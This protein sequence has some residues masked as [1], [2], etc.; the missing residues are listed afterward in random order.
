MIA[1][2][3]KLLPCATLMLATAT[4]F[5]PSE[6][7]ACS[8]VT[9]VRNGVRVVNIVCAPGDAAVAPFQTTNP[10]DGS[11]IDTLTMTGGSIVATGAATPRVDGVTNLDPSAGVIDLLGG[12]DIVTISGGTIGTAA[13]PIGIVLGAGADTFNMSGG[14]ISGS[15]FGLGGG[16]I[17]RVSGG[18]IVGSLFA[19]SQNDLVTI[20]GS[21]N[22]LGDTTIGPDFVGLEDGNDRFIMT[23]GTL[24]GAVSGGN[25]NDL[26]TISGGT[27]G[28][29]VAGNA[30]IDRVVISGGTIAGDVEAET[31]ILSGGTI[32]GNIAGIGSTTLLINDA[33]S[34]APINLRNG[35]V[36]SGTAA[37]A[38]IA[39]T[40][41]AAG[42]TKTQ[43]FSGFATVSTSN[44]TLGF[45]SGAIGIGTLNLTNGS[46]L[47]VRGNASMAG[48]TNVTGGSAISMIN[49]AAGDVFTLG[50][51]TLNNGQLGFDVNQRTLTADRLVAGA[52]TATGTNT[53]NVNLLG[54]PVFSR[55]TDIPI[56]VTGG[57]AAGT[58]VAQGLPG[59]QASL[60][61]YQV[62]TGP[63][64]LFVR[65]TPANVGIALATQNAVDTSSIETAL[66]AIYGINRDAMDVDLGLANGT[67]RAQIA[68]T[69]AV[70]A[71]G[72]LAHTEHDGFTITGG[73]L[74]GDGPSFG[75]D[76][77]SAAISLDFDAAKH[78]AFDQEYG[79]NLG[80]FAGYASTDVS[81]DPFLGFTN[82][83]DATNRAGMIGGYGLFRKEYSYALVSATAFL[84]ETDIFNGVL[85]A[86]GNYG[87]KGYAVTGSIGHIFKLSDTMRFDLRGGLLGVTFRGDD[88]ADSNGNQYG[89]S[90]I[91]FGAVKFEPGIY[92]DR[93]L[94]NGMIFSPYVRADLQQRFGYTNTASLDTR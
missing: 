88:Y 91:S 67:G 53:V 16:N 15:V 58:F 48:T 75:A 12:N 2:F 62:L 10:T 73:G 59:T 61:T 9:A 54:T 87:T 71:S 93:Q 39:N 52:L 24:R 83:G 66:D 38:S 7:S 19:G 82:M 43:V 40:D 20:S 21:A 78:F 89:G 42:G 27:I 50:G 22:I 85:N 31:V 11:G 26:L 35:V 57:P 18:T 25:G 3:R 6:A 80:L 81:L 70:F 44:S 69:L 64:G 13:S 23:G 1:N 4:V 56:V 49:G 72:Q 76:D 84:G 74:S 63:G 32:G 92:M 36:I 68:S 46:T 79:L 30:G 60:F 28:G 65:A 37:V 86:S 34:G 5:L 17:Y 55:Q 94:E 8:A 29:Y 90:E 45:G 47:F 41:L 77:F 14:T 51:L 33:G